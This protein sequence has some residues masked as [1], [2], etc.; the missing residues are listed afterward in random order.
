MNPTEP[1]PT[2]PPVQPDQPVQPIPVV[3]PNPVAPVVPQAQPIPFAA[4]PPQAVVAAPVTPAPIPEAA[5]VAALAPAGI[6]PVLP[7]AAAVEE[8]TFVISSLHKYDTPVKIFTLALVSLFIIGSVLGGVHVL[9][10]RSYSYSQLDWVKAKKAQDGFG[11][12]LVDRSDGTLDMSKRFDTKYTTH[13]QN[14]TAKVGQQINLSNGTTMIITK[15][16]P[17][18]PQPKYAYLAKPDDQLVKIW[19]TFG[20]RSKKTQYAS[21][22]FDYRKPDGTTKLASSLFLLDKDL[23]PGENNL[24]DAPNGYD[25]GQTFTGVSVLEFPAGKLPNLIYQTP[26]A[27]IVREGKS[28]ESKPEVV[29]LKVEITL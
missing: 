21:P 10:V 11:P 22:Y 20:N 13:E 28:L 16:D 26:S 29:H 9:K 1:I 12:E 17:N 14:I 7:V 23:L 27:A 8:P 24:R 19:A 2:Q 25:P 15:V 18:F 3:A 6:S 4:P 5:P